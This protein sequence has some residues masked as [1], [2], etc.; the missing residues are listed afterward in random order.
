MKSEELK[1]LRKELKIK[2][3]NE[4]TRLLKKQ[5][6]FDFVNEIDWDEAD[7]AR[8]YEKLDELAEECATIQI[9]GSQDDYYAKLLAVG[10]D[11]LYIAWEVDLSIQ[12]WVSFSKVHGSYY[13]IEVIEQMEKHLK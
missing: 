1:E 9:T 11:G 10:K 8:D 6:R 3:A 5:H 7:E 2:T 12:T 4:F 13:E